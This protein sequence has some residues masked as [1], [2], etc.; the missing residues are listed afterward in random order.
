MTYTVYGQI[1][2]IELEGMK[3]LWV[4]Q[5]VDSVVMMEHSNSNGANH[6]SFELIHYGEIS[7]DG[8]IYTLNSARH[9]GFSG[10]YL[11]KIDA[12]T[13]NQVWAAPYDLRSDSH[14][15]APSYYRLVGDEIEVMGFRNPLKGTSL[16]AKGIPELRYFS[17]E[18][19]T[20]TRLVYG[21]TDAASLDWFYDYTVMVPRSEGYCFFDK[22]Y[23]SGEDENG[24]KDS[25]S[26][27]DMDAN[28]LERT[29]IVH[30]GKEDYAHTNSYSA[31]HVSE[32]T[33]ANIASYSA[34]EDYTQRQEIM[35]R[36]FDTDRQEYTIHDLSDILE[37]SAGYT[38]ISL[39]EKKAVIQARKYT[40]DEMEWRGKPR[41]YTLYFVDLKSGTATSMDINHTEDADFFST[42]VLALPQDKIVLC[43]T[44]RVP[45]EKGVF[46]EDYK[47]ILV[48]GDKKV[49]ILREFSAEKEDRRYEFRS[50]EQVTD[51]VLVF[52]GTK[53]IHSAQSRRSY[54][55]S[56]FFIGVE[57]EEYGLVSSSAPVSVAAPIRI[58]PNPAT[59]I[60]RIDGIQPHTRIEV[61]D[62][63]GRKVETRMAHSTQELLDIEA[64]SRGV[65]MIHAIQ[66]DG[67]SR[68][69]KLV[70]L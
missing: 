57:A 70:K 18:D 4:H 24:W 59:T 65:Y 69:T 9:D 1:E 42:R 7:A 39:T 51:D 12:A 58:S 64:W 31:F 23:S 40:Y 34:E 15:S 20:Q 41:I 6:M 36:V 17:T 11:Q 16:W 55:N 33:V 52:Y 26:Y 38:I 8:C 66:S 62:E 48:D 29:S 21:S 35:M 27:I 22:Y 50:C 67:Q 10:G 45:S 49:R 19:G 53:A 28:I 60:V 3:P 61:V 5:T 43:N 13:G 2:S 30:K 54:L 56:S 44:Y 25:I 68:T 32:S 47:I 63:L 37:P 14:Q 46:Q